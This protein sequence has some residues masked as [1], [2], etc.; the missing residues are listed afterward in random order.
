MRMIEYYIRNTRI[1]YGI[2]LFIIYMVLFGFIDTLSNKPFD[3]DVNLPV[4]LIF[5]V[6]FAATKTNLE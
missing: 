1:G 3:W 5:S 4:A 6:I 2:F